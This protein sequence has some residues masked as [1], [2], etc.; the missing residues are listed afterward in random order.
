MSEPTATYNPA[1]LTDLDWMR[2]ALG[3]TNTAAPFAPDV[4]FL[5]Y[6]DTAGNVWRLAA[7]ALAR[8]LASRA[9]NQPN[10]ISSPGDGS[11]SWGDRAA[12][13]LRIAA[14]LE[15]EASRL[16]VGSGGGLWV[17]EVERSDMV[18]DDGE[19]SIEL[20]RY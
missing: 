7:A 15:A 10:S 17:A 13:W 3:D 19:Y 12:A 9:I 14:E 2:H 8:S 11:L 16:G 18:L 6:L 4:T 1:L 20:R 5:A